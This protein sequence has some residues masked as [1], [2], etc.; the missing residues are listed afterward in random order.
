LQDAEKRLPNTVWSRAY[1]TAYEAGQAPAAGS[2]GNH[3]HWF[4]FEK[5]YEVRNMLKKLAQL[6]F[7]VKLCGGITGL[8]DHL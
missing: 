5:P 4:I 7:M 3:P 2:A 1:I 6:I 8:T